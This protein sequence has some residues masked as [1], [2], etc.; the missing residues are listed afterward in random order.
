MH[1]HLTPLPY[2]VHYVPGSNKVATTTTI[3]GKKL[4]LYKD[5]DK[6]MAAKARAFGKV[7]KEAYKLLPDTS[8][9]V[10]VIPQPD[11]ALH[12]PWAE[13]PGPGNAGPGLRAHL[14]SLWRA[15]GSKNPWGG[16]A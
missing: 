1:A 7:L 8:K 9:K 13:M 2:G 14:E 12:P 16:G 10:T 5:V 4:T 6:L 11:L 15:K 3:N